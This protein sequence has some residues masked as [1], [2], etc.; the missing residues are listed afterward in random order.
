[1]NNYDCW[2]VHYSDGKIATAPIVRNVHQVLFIAD[3]KTS[4]TYPGTA[5]RMTKIISVF[6]NR[7]IGNKHRHRR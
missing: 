4:T 2:F 6:Q 3:A 1:M 7:S 5:G